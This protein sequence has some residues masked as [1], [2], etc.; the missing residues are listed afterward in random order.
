MSLRPWVGP[1]FLL[2][3]AAYVGWNN[4]TSLNPIVLVGLDRLVGPNPYVQG[5]WTWRLLAGLA[6]LYGL[7]IGIHVRRRSREP[8]PED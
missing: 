4:Q 1:I 5:A 7:G 2:G 8:D 6:G 3:V